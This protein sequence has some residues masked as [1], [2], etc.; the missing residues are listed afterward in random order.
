MD[1][2]QEFFC[3]RHLAD[4]MLLHM[5]TRKSDSISPLHEDE[6]DPGETDTDSSLGIGN[7]WM[8]PGS[9][10]PVWELEQR[11]DGGMRAHIWRSIY[12]EMSVEWD[13]LWE[14]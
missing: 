12:E 3:T 4:E 1:H 5:Q 6:A 14:H 11:E 10:V 2:D 9:D 8:F 7:S 13:G